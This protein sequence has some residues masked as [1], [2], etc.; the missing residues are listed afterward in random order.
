MMPRRCRKFWQWKNGLAKSVRAPGSRL[1]D[2]VQQPREL[3]LPARGRHVVP[4]LVVENDDARGIAL[5]AATGRQID[6]ARYRA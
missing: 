3:A 6:A 4:D 1:F 2:G 5:L